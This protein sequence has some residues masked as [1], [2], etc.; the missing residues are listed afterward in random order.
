M[1]LTPLHVAYAWPLKLRF[2][3]LV[4]SSLT[5]GSVIP[6]IEVPVLGVLGYNPSRLV[7]H[8][9]IGAVTIDVL[10]V[11]IA[12][13]LISGLRVERLGF[14]GFNKVKLDGWFLLSGAIGAISHV[15]IDALHHEHNP[16][17]WPFHPNYVGSIGFNIMGA[18]IHL[19]ANFASVAVL[20]VLTLHVLGRSKLTT[21]LRSPIK[22]LD[23][24][25]A[26]LAN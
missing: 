17:F 14:R 3:R 26:K 6:D 1:P 5:I 9:L 24:I 12:A 11:I 13:H 2:K 15:L 10:L 16:I 7:T 22:T 25:T 18:S 20:L 23:E 8:S 4:F 19:V 21:A